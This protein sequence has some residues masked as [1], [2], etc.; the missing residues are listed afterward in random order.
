MDPKPKQYHHI[1]FLY[2][3]MNS[4]WFCPRFQEMASKFESTLQSPQVC[5]AKQGINSV[6]EKSTL[7]RENSLQ[8]ALT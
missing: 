1:N 4:F 5:I 3:C 2:F 8:P 6:L 7:C